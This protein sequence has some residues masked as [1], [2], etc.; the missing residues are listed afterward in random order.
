MIQSQRTTVSVEQAQISVF[1]DPTDKVTALTHCFERE[2]DVRPI[3][4]LGEKKDAQQKYTCVLERGSIQLP[5][6]MQDYAHKDKVLGSF[7][8]IWHAGETTEERG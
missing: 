4:W 1:Y 2:L 6:G 7:E 8:G 3:I 5:G